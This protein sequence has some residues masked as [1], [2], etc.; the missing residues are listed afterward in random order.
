MMGAGAA[1]AVVWASV[2][3]WLV[4]LSGFD[5]R[6]GRLPNLLTV[7]GAV[8]V[9]CGATAVGRGWPALAGAVAL[10]VTYLVVHLIAPA[11]LGAG[12][13]K[14]A[15]GLGALAG[16][17]GLDVWTLAAVGAP[18]LTALGGLAALAVGYRGALPHGPSMCAATAAAVAATWVC[19]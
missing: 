17:H 11:A 13:V 1:H 16:A 18:L 7:P 10:V 2:A 8:A 4:A 12:D 9:L 19:V 6:Q 14:L 5:I 15:V 3:V